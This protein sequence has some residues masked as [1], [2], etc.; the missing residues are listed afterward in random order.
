M[1]YSKIFICNYAGHDVSDAFRYT[2]LSPEEAQINLTE[3]NVDIFDVDRLIYFIKN[4]LKE[5]SPEDYLLLSGGN[6]LNCIAFSIWLQMHGIV[7]ILIYNAK[8]KR[9]ILREITHTKITIDI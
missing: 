9:Y 2:K 7:K 8:E 1:T 4:R 6:I 3:G 5:S